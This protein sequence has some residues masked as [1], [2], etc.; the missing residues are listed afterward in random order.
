[1]STQ[2]YE[3]NVK[4]SDFSKKETR[5]KLITNVKQSS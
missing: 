2:L 4:L 5:L 3:I 1:M